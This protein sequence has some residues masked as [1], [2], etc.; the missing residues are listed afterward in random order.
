M[1][2]VVLCV[3]SV[4]STN[5]RM[6]RILVMLHVSACNAGITHA[7]GKESLFSLQIILIYWNSAINA[8]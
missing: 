6:E 5:H 4:T 2:K 1:T 7:Q 8:I 3:V